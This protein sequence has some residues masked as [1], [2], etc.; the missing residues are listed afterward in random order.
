MRYALIS[1]NVEFVFFF[2]FFS[3]AI[4]QTLFIALLTIE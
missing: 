2:F 1:L 4:L 3:T